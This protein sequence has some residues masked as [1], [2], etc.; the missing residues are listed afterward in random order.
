MTHS[1]YL[2]LQSQIREIIDPHT[3]RRRYIRGTGEIIERI[4]SRQE[5]SQLN[6]CA[7]LGDGSGYTNDIMRAAAAATAPSTSFTNVTRR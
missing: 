5:H 7:T 4:V 6:K 1:Q 3:G 2:T